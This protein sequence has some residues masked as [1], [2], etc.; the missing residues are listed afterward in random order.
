MDDQQNRQMIS[1]GQQVTVGGPGAP[2]PGGR[3]R[4][5]KKAR[6]FVWPFGA[7][8]L[9][10][11]IT[12][13]A[14]TFILFGIPTLA[15]ILT[16]TG[17]VRDVVMNGGREDPEEFNDDGESPNGNS[18]EA[19]E[20]EGE[21]GGND[22]NGG[23]SSGSGN[24]SGAGGGNGNGSGGNG[25]SG[26][27]GSGGS[28]GGESDPGGG[29]EEPASCAFPNFPD[30]NCTGWQHTG[31]A[32]HTSGCPTT[33][34]TDNATYDSCRFT[35]TLLIDASNVTITRS[36]IEGRVVPINSP[37][38]SL[39]GLTLTDVE[40]DGQGAWDFNQAAIGNSDYT[41]TRCH[42]HS[43]GRG[44]NIIDNVV[45]KDSYLHGW[46]TQSGDHETAIGS[47]GGSGN[48]I[49]HNN[50]VCDSSGCSSALSLYGDFAQINDWLIEKNLFA[51]SSGGY[52]THAGSD[53]G[54]PFPNAT[55][56][57]Y[58][59]NYFSKQYNA[60]CGVFGPVTSWAFNTGNVWSGNVWADGSGT[61]TP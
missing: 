16:N 7:G 1:D 17:G 39:R 46:V 8:L 31:V 25:S 52:C 6:Q 48:Q 26:G 34:T 23:S 38:D 24:G 55:N 20:E 41:C 19:P 29:G 30:E 53:S 45:I 15:L 10:R 27:S 18:E 60:Q 49:T 4:W 13:T 5:F 58:I 21:E 14:A 56:I 33:I 2:V 44:A 11:I 51:T 43:T 59:D 22:S 54:K 57:R 37:D 61:V 50:V 35:G 32:L 12:V 42:I 36:K 9:R 3:W 47:N 40:V 28:S